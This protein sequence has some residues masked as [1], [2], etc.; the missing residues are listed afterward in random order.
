MNKQFARPI[1][2]Y[3]LFFIVFFF[4]TNIV[5][6]IPI[7]ETY[8]LRKI[9]DAQYISFSR[10]FPAYMENFRRS[11]DLLF[12][13]EFMGFAF[14]PTEQESIEK[15]IKLVFASEENRYEVSTE[16]L[17]RF[18]LRNLFRENKVVGINHG[19]ITRFSPLN[20]KNGVYRL[21]IY[22][23]ENENTIGFLETDMVFE[24]TYRSFKELK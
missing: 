22:C 14:I 8:R 7:N 4:S 23:Y 2:V 21:Y 17:D 9:D 20:M 1:L 3:I 24:K 15:E 10:E 18:N 13:V 6:S 12:T 11:E 5:L 16:V 19:F